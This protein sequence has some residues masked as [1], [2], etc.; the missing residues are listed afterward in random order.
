MKQLFLPLPFA[1]YF[2]C[3]YCTQDLSE[4]GGTCMELLYSNFPIA[5]P[6][7]GRPAFFFS[8]PWAPC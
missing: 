5:D 1:L 4:Q 2:Y 6:C 7:Q 3:L 8:N